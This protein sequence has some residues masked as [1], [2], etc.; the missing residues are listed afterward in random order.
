MTD[1]GASHAADATDEELAA[2]V[3]AALVASG[4]RLAVAESLTGGLLTAALVGVPGASR[5]LTGGIVSY[6]TALKRTLLGVESSILAVHGAVHPDVA[7]QMARG[8]RQACEVDGRPAD[9]GVSTT[10]AA[11]PDPQDGQA[12]GTAFVGLS[13]DGDSRAIPLHL[14]GD[15]QEVRAG[16]VHEA[17]RAL[18]DALGSGGNI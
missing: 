11:G 3:I 15:R 8:V 18:A 14:H 7:R 2:R 6:D 4:R 1:V 16:V 9:V 12:P 5:A 13:L 17:L 10:G